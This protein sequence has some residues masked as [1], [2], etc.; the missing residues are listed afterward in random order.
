MKLISHVEDLTSALDDV[1]ASGKRIGF[2]PTMGY[3][4]AGHASLIAEARAKNDAVV[5][6]LFVNPTQFGANEDLDRYPR[7]LEADRLV[8]EKAGVDILF[9]PSVEEMYPA[10]VDATE[11]ISIPEMSNKLDGQF[12][13]GHFDGVTT[14]MSKFFSIVGSCRCYMGMKDAQQVLILQQL[15]AQS[16]GD[17]E[18]VACPTIRDEGGLALSSRNTY[19]TIDQREI[20]LS[21]FAMLDNVASAIEQGNIDVHT[22]C[23]HAR[24][25]LEVAGFTI[26][27]FDF[28]DRTTLDSVTTPRVSGPYLLCVA[29]LIGNTRLIDNFFIDFVDGRATV[30]RGIVAT[31]MISSQENVATEA[32][33]V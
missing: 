23:E 15:V 17:C 3:L 7:D 21:L 26:Q 27:Y 28:V 11:T 24:S 31:N 25:T 13:T 20:A 9:Y 14:V 16:F 18:I 5:V 2:V 6:S 33:H 12:R 22:L 8:C 10:G 1:R 4:H 29:A 19:L 32:P 30:D